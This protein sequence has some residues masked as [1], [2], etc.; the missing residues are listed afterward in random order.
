M[1]SPADSPRQTPVDLPTVA[2]LG[3]GSM[4]RAILAGLLAENVRVDGGIRIT[5]RSAE[6]AG[7][8]DAEPRV[9]AWVTS[10]HE[11]ANREAVTGARVVVLAVKPAQIAQLATEIAPALS[12]N[13]IVVSVAAGVT[14]ATIEAALESA[15]STGASVIRAMPNTP[16]AIRLGMTG[17]SSGS[18]A[19]DADVQLVASVF[20]TVGDVLVVPE[21]QLDALTTIS[22][23][24]PAYVFYFLEQLEAAA[25]SRGFTPEEAALLA[26]STFRGA[27]QYAIE[28]EHTPAELRRAVTSPNGTTERAIAVFDAAN[29]RATLDEAT[30]AS[31]A[32]ARELAA[33]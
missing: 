30:A 20:A 31:L 13:A 25:V 16:A 15:A 18:T 32:R 10:T 27:S 21:A 7:D 17:L 12:E 3:A 2:I 5:N 9:M 8:F 33:G 22:G 14:C 6:R 29:I 19:T 11:N 24:G 26:R 1:T 23:S 28:S 4:G